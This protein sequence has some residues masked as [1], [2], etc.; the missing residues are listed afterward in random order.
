[1]RLP[2]IAGMIK[3]GTIELTD[4]GAHGISPSNRNR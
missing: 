1:M 4:R 3:Y 2:S